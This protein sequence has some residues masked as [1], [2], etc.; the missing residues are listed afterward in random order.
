VIAKS[1]RRKLV[2]TAVFCYELVIMIRLSPVLVALLCGSTGVAQEFT[3]VLSG[4]NEVPPNSSTVVGTA[5]LRIG[6][7]SD[8][9]IL[10]INITLPCGRW[11]AGIHGPAPAGAIGPR[12]ADFGTGRCII[13]RDGTRSS[14]WVVGIETPLQS[15]QIAQAK[16]GLWYINVTSELFPDGEVRGQLLPIDSDGDGIPDYLDQCPATHPGALVR[17]RRV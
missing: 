9:Y 11:P 6:V 17:W 3:T 10:V 15:N 16:A 2:F 1:R 4:T 14:Q 12:I 8:P 5:Y 13:N 7:S